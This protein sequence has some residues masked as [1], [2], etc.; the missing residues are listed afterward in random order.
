M[1]EREIVLITISFIFEIAVY[2]A[3]Y[4]VP[5]QTVR[6]YLIPIYPY[7]W[8]IGTLLP[9]DLLLHFLAISIA[10]GSMSE[11]YEQGTVDFFLTKPI[12]RL[13]FYI[14]KWL[15][16]FSLLVVIYVLMVIL[17]LFLSYT[18]FGVQEYLE[19]FWI[20]IISVIFSSLVFFC[21]SFSVGEILRRSSLSFIIS[22]FTLIGSILVSDVLLFI[23]FLTNNTS[24]E[25]IATYLP[26]WGSTQLPFILLSS[27]PLS[28]ITQ[29]IDMFPIQGNAWVAVLSIVVYTLIP[30]VISLYLFSR[31]DIPK[32]IS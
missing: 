7:T 30:F 15:G 32:R 19:Y 24:Y 29:F 13:Q 9:Q 10:S 6:T 18:L 28:N 12:T 31:R 25:S 16:S 5:S 21:I 26:S 23:S 8:A 1:R 27:S 14:Q 22:S 20:T 17:S 4:L 11:E 2:L 3:L